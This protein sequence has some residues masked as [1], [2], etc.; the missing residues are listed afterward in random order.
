MPTATRCTVTGTLP[1]LQGRGGGNG[2]TPGPLPAAAGPERCS[3]TSP[4]PS[5]VL[6]APRRAEGQGCVWTMGPL[7]ASTQ[8]STLSPGRATPALPTMGLFPCVLL[9]T[10]RDRPL[11]PQSRA[12]AAPVPS[13]LRPSGG[14]GKCPLLRVQGN[15]C[16][17]GVL[18]WPHPRQLD[19][20]R[21]RIEP[22]SQE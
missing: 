8:G 15:A 20:P 16:G 3:E 17:A 5:V 22:K 6:C 21:P 1:S 4:D 19:V 18:F 7:S 2:Q 14:R 12:V 11:G 9:S 10:P 13:G